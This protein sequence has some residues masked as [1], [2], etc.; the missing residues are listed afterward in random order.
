VL[1]G[2]YDIGIGE[3]QELK[4]Q[5]DA[6]KVRLLAVLTDKRLDGLPNLATA[7]EQ[8]FNVVVTKFR[9]LAAPKGVSDEIAAAWEAALK[10]VLELPA[11]KAEYGRENLIPRLMGR[12]EARKF[13]AQFAKDTADSFKE[14]GI[15][16]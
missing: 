10:R 13:T 1:N 9:G 5:L 11:Y 16:K 14:M 8:G 7:K 12:A 6:G 15:I 3:M 2:T 4:A